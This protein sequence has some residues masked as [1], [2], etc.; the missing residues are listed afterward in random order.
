MSEPD[1]NHTEDRP[2]KE[3]R[4]ENIFE[5]LDELI[6]HMNTTRNVFTLLIITSLII[7]PISLILGAVVTG[8]PRFLNFLVTRMPEIGFLILAYVVVSI[9]LAAIWLY[10]GIKERKFF[11][12]WDMKFRRYM[13]LKNQIDRELEDEGAD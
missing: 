12:K 8:H 1:S 13:S 2:K 5:V 6:F 4:R 9:I 3:S 10:I 11:S 7:A